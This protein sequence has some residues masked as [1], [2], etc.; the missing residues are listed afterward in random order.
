MNDP[1]SLTFSAVWEKQL[2]DSVQQQVTN[3]LFS[4]YLPSK[5][6]LGYWKPVKLDRTDGST[7]QI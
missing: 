4:G 6:A 7:K 1:R 2:Y 3:I 5:A